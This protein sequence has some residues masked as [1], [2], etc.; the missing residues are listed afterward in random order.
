M[1]LQSLF[2]NTG[3]PSNSQFSS[4]SDQLFRVRHQLMLEIYHKLT[5]AAALIKVYWLFL[6]IS[7]KPVIKWAGGWRC[8]ITHIFQHFIILS[9]SHSQGFMEACYTSGSIRVCQ[10]EVVEIRTWLKD[11]C[12]I[13][14]TTSSWLSTN[15]YNSFAPGISQRVIWTDSLIVISEGGSDIIQSRKKYEKSVWCF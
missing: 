13:E 2:P 11:G 14:N 5:S 1:W 12:W 3:S 7:M 9:V 6:R 4:R 8:N 10:D 15:I